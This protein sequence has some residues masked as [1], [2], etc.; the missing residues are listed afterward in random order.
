MKIKRN[1]Q[2]LEV[3]S[4][5]YIIREPLSGGQTDCPLCG[6]PMLTAEQSAGIFSITQRR[7][8][9]IIENDATHYAEI[10]TSAVMICL[11]SLAKFLD[12]ER[13]KL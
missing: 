4:R 12:D 1:T 2:L 11:A 7:I 5:R 10:E 8:F 13:E 9:Q 6:E 3:I